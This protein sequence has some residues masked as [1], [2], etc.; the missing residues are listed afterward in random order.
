[1][2]Y[3][4]FCLFFIS[5]QTSAQHSLV[6][7]SYFIVQMSAGYAIQ[8]KVFNLTTQFGYKYENLYVS[9]NLVTRLSRNATL[10]FMF[11]NNIGYN[12]GSFQPFIS[13]GYHFIGKE[14][15]QRFRNTPDQFLNGWRPGYGISYYYPLKPISFTIQQQGDQTLLSLGIYQSF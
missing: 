6:K 13:Y 1:M 11:I 2:K 10:P 15:E 5:I 7:K 9:T 14:A 4:L 3:L 8:P 12:I